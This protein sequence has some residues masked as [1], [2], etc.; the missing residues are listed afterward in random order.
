VKQIPDDNTSAYFTVN[1]NGTNANDRY[2][3]LLFLDTDGQL[4]Y[5]NIGD[6]NSYVSYF[7]DA[8]T[9]SQDLGLLSGTDFDRS[10]AVSVAQYAI[11]SGGPLMASPGNNALL[12]YAVEGQPA[13]QVTYQPR[14]WVDDP[15]GPGG[16]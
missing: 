12:V 2:L 14:Y 11:I 5:V 13:L 16:P 1:V 15:G 4:V 9:A 3:D 6:G 8:P 10:S 7:L